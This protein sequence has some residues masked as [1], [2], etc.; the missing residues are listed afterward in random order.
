VNE[1]VVSEDLDSKTMPLLD[2]LIELRS[3]LIKA[4]IAIVVAFIACYAVGWH[5]YDFLIH[6][7]AVAVGEGHRMI[8]TA[9]QEAFFTRVKVGIFGALFLACPIIASQIWMFVAPG[10]YKHERR[11]FFPFLSATPILFVM[12]ASL[13]YFVIMPLA[14]KFFASFQTAGGPGT[15]PI[16]LEARVSEYLNLVTTLML[17]FGACF[18]L[19]ILL[20]L[21]ARIGLTDSKG[22]RKKRRYAIVIV[23]I[24]AAVLTPPDP[25]SQISLALPILALYEGSIILVRI[26]ERKR[27]KEEQAEDAGKS[28]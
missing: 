27:E 12:G 8:Y 16:V 7:Y 14:L 2:H 11:A 22:L 17:A 5:I 15:V 19:P 23:F 24:V 26:T 1:P 3:R 21:M 25:I 18:Q 28:G 6:P 4:I 10:L 20:T 9:P 13:V